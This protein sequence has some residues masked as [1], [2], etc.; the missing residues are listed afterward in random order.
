MLFRQSLYLTID[1][2][3]YR[4]PFGYF[5]PEGLTFLAEKSSYFFFGMN[6]NNSQ[7]MLF[8]NQIKKRRLLW[9]LHCK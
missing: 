9:L 4:N 3:V 7:D 1:F 2:V 6:L 8:T 5:L